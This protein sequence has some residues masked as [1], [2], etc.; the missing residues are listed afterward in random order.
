M[1]QEND[2]YP[3][4]FVSMKWTPLK[5][6]LLILFL[7]TIG[8]ASRPTVTSRA[9]DGYHIFLPNV[10]I[11][12]EVDEPAVGYATGTDR[13]L[14]RWFCTTQ[15]DTQYEVYR[16]TA[17]GVYNLL[18][19]V[20][21]QADA[22]TAILTLNATDSRW[23]SLYDDLLEEY[24]EQGVTTIATLYDMLDENML[25]AQKLTNEYYP[26]A[27]INGWGYLD[28]NFA[29]GTT[30]YYR[31]ERAADGKV[32][33][34]VK[35]EAGQLTPLPAPQNVQALQLDPGISELT[36][37]K[38]ADWGEVQADRR[39]DQ[40]AQMSWDVVTN[41]NNYP[42]EWTIGYDIFRAP[43]DQPDALIQVNGE[44]SVQPIAA[45]E[46]NIVDSSVILGGA[47]GQDYQM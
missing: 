4:Q 42:P 14:I 15:C 24:E 28:T 33:G 23:P 6:L 36:H 22:A 11:R 19:T 27:L 32:V 37:A 34:E 43:A 46:P 8:L 29:A 13:T 35:L 41:N 38:E 10:A 12:A 9:D 2:S 17:N 18:A 39:F 20:G 16:R 25:V 45:T 40:V 5:A 7:F 21:R 31:V 30:Y 1:N 47:A 3:H 44:I 26:V